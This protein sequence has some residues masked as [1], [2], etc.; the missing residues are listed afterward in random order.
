MV[1]LISNFGTMEV[2]D[3]L[4]APA[5]YSREKKRGICLSPSTLHKDLE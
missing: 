1:P 3:Q 5:L 2:T 4:Q